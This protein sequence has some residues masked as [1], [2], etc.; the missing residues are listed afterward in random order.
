MKQT[1]PL[2]D[3]PLTAAVMDGWKARVALP[4]GATLELHPEVIPRPQAFESR[5]VL[6][7][8][9]GGRPVAYA[10][11]GKSDRE[12]ADA[13][14][15]LLEHGDLAAVLRGS[16]EELEPSGATSPTG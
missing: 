11:S 14:R 10:F 16:S 13:L 2:S 3:F 12:L 1:L 9:T 8:H 5:A 4:S 7:R 6:T 15:Y